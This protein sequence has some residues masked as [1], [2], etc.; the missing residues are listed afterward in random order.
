MAE[1]RVQRRPAAILAAELVRL[2]FD[3]IVAGGQRHSDADFR[4]C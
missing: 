1:E 2:N 3:V 4:S